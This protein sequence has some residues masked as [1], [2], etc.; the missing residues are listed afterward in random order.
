MQA[1][2][3][4]N[5]LITFL[6]FIIPNRVQMANIWPVEP[7]ME[8]L[9]FL[10]LQLASSSTRWKVRGDLLQ[11]GLINSFLT[12]VAVLSLLPAPLYSSAA[13][14]LLSCVYR[15]TVLQH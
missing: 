3:S 14:L 9:T 1:N 8:L 4:G 15:N 11:G 13:Y 7:S 2:K 6:Y 10:I 12:T 5:T